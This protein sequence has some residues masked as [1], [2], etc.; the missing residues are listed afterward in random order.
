MKLDDRWSTHS[1]ES[2]ILC[3]IEDETPRPWHQLDELYNHRS[4]GG[5]VIQWLYQLRNIKSEGKISS[6]A[7]RKAKGHERVQGG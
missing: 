7:C 2:E 1:R 3:Q 4:A 5:E 6:H